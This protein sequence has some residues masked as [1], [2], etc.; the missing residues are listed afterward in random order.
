MTV[1][2]IA[3]AKNETWKLVIPPSGKKLIGFRW[4][5]TIKHKDDGLLERFKVRLVVQGFN[6][7]YGVN[8]QKTFTPVAKMNKIIILLSYAAN[9]D[10]ELQKL[11]VK[12]AF[13]HGHLE[14]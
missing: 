13:L 12:N 14:E 2:M 1:E 8:Y 3:L 4:V 9:L 11:D 6:Q 7:T 10:W 5:F